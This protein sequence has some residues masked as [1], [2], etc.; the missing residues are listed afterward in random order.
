MFLACKIIKNI[1]IIFYDFKFLKFKNYGKKNY[2][3]TKLQNS[4]IN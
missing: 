1:S 3:I 4:F 2:K